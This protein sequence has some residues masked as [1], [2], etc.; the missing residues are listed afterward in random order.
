[1]YS[2]KD[3]PKTRFSHVFIFAFNKKQV[4]KISINKKPKIKKNKLKTSLRLINQSKR[5][6][7][8]LGYGIRSS[9][10]SIPKIKKLISSKGIPFVTTWNGADLISTKNK[11]NLGIIGMSGQRGANKAVFSSDLLL[12]IGTHLSI[13]QTTTLTKN[14]AINSKKIIVDIDNN[15][16]DNL[17]IKFDC[18]INGDVKDYLK[19]IENKKIKKFYWQ[20][21]EKFKKMNWYLPEKTREP[22]SNFFIHTLTSKVK[23][24]FCLVVDGGGTALY[25]G[26]QSSVIKDSDRII[27]SSAIS[28]MG[29]GLAETV[30]VWKSGLFKKIICVIGDGS[31]LMNVQDLQTISQHNINVAIIVVNNNG[32]LAIRNTQKEFLG[33]KYYGTHPE[34]NLTMPSFKKVSNAFGIDY[35]KISNSS[36]IGKAIDKIKFR[37]KPIICE[38]MVNED[39][40]PLFKQGYSKDKNGKFTPQTLEEMYPFLNIPIANTNN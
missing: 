3:I 22:N 39:Q 9:Q 29:T 13:P 15:Q 35:L 26:F 8:V 23:D 28:S 16:L 32:Y 10:N 1:L 18:K 4:K 19:L 31:L 6:L 5:P 24:K 17:S 36:Q 30:G 20:N 33:G 34:W 40:E 38:L 37:K 11:F 25:A 14:Y 21:L 2:A 12:C 7:F 27:C